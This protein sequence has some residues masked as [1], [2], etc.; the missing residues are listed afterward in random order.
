MANLNNRVNDIV[1][2]YWMKGDK[3]PFYQE[4]GDIYYGRTGN[5]VKILS[6]KEKSWKK[7]FN[8]MKVSDQDL[9]DLLNHFHREKK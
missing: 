4:D 5:D 9:I 6:G 3:N 8:N 1:K 2:S 7:F